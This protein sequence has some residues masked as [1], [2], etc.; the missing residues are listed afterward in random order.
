M[1]CRPELRPI[2]SFTSRYNNLHQHSVMWEETPRETDEC[3]RA[4]S[5]AQE[6]GGVDE[7]G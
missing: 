2:S 1:G 5:S 7:R 4:E 6:D 3:E